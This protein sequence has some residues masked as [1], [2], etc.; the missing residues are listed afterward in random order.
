MIFTGLIL[1]IIGTILVLD[2]LYLFG[3]P[4]GGFLGDIGYLDPTQAVTDVFHH[5]MVGVVLIVLGVMFLS[6]DKTLIRRKH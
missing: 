5:W 3:I 6:N 4:F 1:M 2:Q